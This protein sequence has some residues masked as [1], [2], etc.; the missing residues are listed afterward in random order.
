[1]GLLEVQEAKINWRPR[2]YVGRSD[3]ET[4]LASTNS[5]DWVEIT[6]MMLGKVP[7]GFSFVPK[8]KSNA[9][10]AE[11]AAGGAAQAKAEEDGAAG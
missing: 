5:K 7:D 1:M 6:E 8:H 9:Y 4:K 2:P 11:G 3:L 10:Q